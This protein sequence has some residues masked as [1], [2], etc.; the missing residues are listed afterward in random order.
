MD[1][2]TEKIVAQVELKNRDKLRLV[3]RQGQVHLIVEG[4]HSLKEKIQQLISDQ[5]IEIKSW[6]ITGVSHAD[7]LIKKLIFQLNEKKHPYAD[8]EVCHCRNISKEMIEENIL[9]GSHS[10]GAL[11][12]T[13]TA[14]TACG[15]CHADVEAILNYWLK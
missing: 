6:K 4:C 11:Q 13:T 12:R 5:G 15:S 8:S 7:L 9:N 3:D 10:V 2:E 14:S 1:S